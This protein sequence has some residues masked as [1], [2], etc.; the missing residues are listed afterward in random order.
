MINVRVAQYYITVHG[1][2]S[3]AIGGAACGGN[4]SSVCAELQIVGLWL[5]GVQQ[6]AV[7]VV[8]FQRIALNW[9]GGV[10]RG[11]AKCGIK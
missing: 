9:Q 10:G 6:F 4:I 1:Y 8:S 7:R 11:M 5:C 3:C 2:Q